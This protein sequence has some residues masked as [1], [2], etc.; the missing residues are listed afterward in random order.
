MVVR[1]PLIDVSQL[2]KELVETLSSPNPE[3]SSEEEYQHIKQHAEEKNLIS[4]N[5][6]III[7]STEGP[8][9]KCGGS[10]EET[11]PT[12]IP[13]LSVDKRVDEHFIAPEA[14]PRICVII[15]Y[16]M[17]K[18][19]F[20][21]DEAEKL[22][23][24]W[25]EK[26]E[27]SV[28]EFA[29]EFNVPACEVVTKLYRDKIELDGDPLTWYHLNCN[30]GGGEFASQAKTVLPS[31][32]FDCSPMH[33]HKQN[34]NYDRSDGFPKF[35]VSYTILEKGADIEANLLRDISRSVG[36][37]QS[38]L[39]I[40]GHWDAFSTI[41]N[42]CSKFAVRYMIQKE[43]GL[44]AQDVYHHESILSSKNLSDIKTGHLN[45][46]SGDNKGEIERSNIPSGMVKNLA[47]GFEPVGEVKMFYDAIVS[48]CTAVN[49]C[50]DSIRYKSVRDSFEHIRDAW[51]DE[52]EKVRGVELTRETWN[53]NEK[54]IKEVIHLLNRDIT[55]F[56]RYKQDFLEKMKG[57]S[58][59][60]KERLKEPIR[61]RTVQQIE[62]NLWEYLL[63]YKIFSEIC[64][65]IMKAL[66][67]ANKIHHSLSKEKKSKLGEFEKRGVKFD[68]L[69]HIRTYGALDKALTKIQLILKKLKE[70][71]EKLNIYNA[72][73]K[74]LMLKLS[75]EPVRTESDFNE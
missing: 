42:T 52:S 43:E 59:R 37:G 67:V 71:P 33:E 45:I 64:T 17:V 38:I 23:E 20:T 21:F 57:N 22:L 44:C 70:S 9:Y 34:Q 62:L 35:T 8:I 12:F 53:V 49:D 40:E 11:G 27:K 48:L 51:R 63:F 74:S 46:N 7:E 4:S 39:K 56:N 16:S 5:Q 55:N 14:D 75:D 73:C 6:I 47:E 18:S 19:E 60:E 3:I 24:N 1:Y 61:S 72:V 68:L 41:L 10:S 69:H 58:P 28:T 2:P 54:N 15:H 31:I 65:Y 50:N 29:S 66:E 13:R 32:L 30:I 25:A 26:I 36:N